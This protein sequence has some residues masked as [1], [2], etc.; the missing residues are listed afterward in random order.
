MI[1]KEWERDDQAKERD[2]A[3]HSCRSSR[4]AHLR[5]RGCAADDHVAAQ[6]SV[7]RIASPE[8]EWIH[9]NEDLNNG[10]Q[11]VITTMPK[12]YGTDIVEQSRS[13]PRWK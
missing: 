2:A 5:R 10:E 3:L 1:K 12:C 8:R 11:T 13:G 7:P 6:G 4:K 9:A